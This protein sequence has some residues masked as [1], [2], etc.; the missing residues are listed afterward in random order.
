MPGTITVAS[1][2]NSMPDSTAPLDSVPVSIQLVGRWR[3]TRLGWPR[4]RV[5]VV[6]EAVDAIQ[7]LA[8][9]LT[10]HG[11]LH[12]DDIARRLRDSGVADPDTL[13][14]ELLDEIDCPVRQLVDDRWVWL[15]TVL[16]GR[17]FT[18]RLG[19][20]EAAHDMLTV[21]SDLDRSPRF[22]S[23]SSTGGSPTGRRCASCWAGSTR[24]CSSSGASRPRWST[25]SGRCSWN[26]ARSGRW[27]W[28]RATWPG[29]G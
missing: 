26:R 10:E 17:V 18:H 19:A 23:T 7:I 4:H 1:Y 3:T 27:G 15:P 8:M 6:A 29:C 9:I 11:P 16:A 20:D 14:E 2:Q 24:S 25:R 13:L 28:P 21:T 22:A 5:V 12:E